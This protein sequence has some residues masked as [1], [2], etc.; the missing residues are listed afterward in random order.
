V[1]KSIAMKWVEALRS[2]EYRQTTSVLRNEDGIGH[3]CLGVLCELSP[4]QKNYMNLSRNKRKNEVLPLV[5]QKWAGMKTANGEFKYSAM[6]ETALSGLNDN[7]DTFE[8]IADLI[9]TYWK[10]L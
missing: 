9:E 5:V 4:N 10:K 8:Q 1:K 7:G 3:C 2:G 6:P